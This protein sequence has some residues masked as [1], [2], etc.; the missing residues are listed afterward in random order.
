[1]GFLLGIQARQAL[2]APR[3]WRKQRHASQGAADAHLR[4]LKRA[5]NVRDTELLNAYPCQ[6]CGA[7]H[8]GRYRGVGKMGSQS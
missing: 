8:V 2:S 7:W 3:C 1:M 4:A 6:D 5:E